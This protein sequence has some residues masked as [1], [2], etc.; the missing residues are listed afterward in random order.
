MVEGLESHSSRHAAVP[1]DGDGP[2]GA[3]LQGIG[4]A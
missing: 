4:G 1:D 2:V 3:A